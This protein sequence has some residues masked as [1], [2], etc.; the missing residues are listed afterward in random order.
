MRKTALGIATAFLCGSAIALLL[1]QT[2][3]ID[4][5]DLLLHAPAAAIANIPCGDAA[6]YEHRAIAPAAGCVF[7]PT[8]AIAEAR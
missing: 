1:V 2:E 4:T 5:V 3:P 6:R 7:G 8:T